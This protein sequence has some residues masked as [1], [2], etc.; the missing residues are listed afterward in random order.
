[1]G[2]QAHRI[3]PVENTQIPV[4]PK[5][6]DFRLGFFQTQVFPK[7]SG[8]WADSAPPVEKADGPGPVPQG[9]SPGL[10]AFPIFPHSGSLLAGRVLV[11]GD[12][13]RV[14]KDFPHLVLQDR[15]DCCSR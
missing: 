13:L 7:K 12:G 6:A 15:P 10:P 2:G 9:L 3:T 4:G 5:V 11:H 1:M 8:L 14:E